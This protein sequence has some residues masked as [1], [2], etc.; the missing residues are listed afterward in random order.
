M[1]SAEMAATL[2]SSTRK[3]DWIKQMSTAQSA[4]QNIIM[5]SSVSTFYQ[6]PKPEQVVFQ[7]CAHA[8]GID[9]AP[10]AYAHILRAVKNAESAVRNGED[11]ARLKNIS[12]RQRTLQDQLRT[13]KA[14][15]ERLEAAHFE[16]LSKGTDS[17]LESARDA[18]LEIQGRIQLI[19]SEISQMNSI[20][21]SARAALG[22]AANAELPRLFERLVAESLEVIEAAAID[23]NAALDSG[24]RDAFTRL[25][26]GFHILGTVGND[27]R[28]LRSV[29]GDLGLSE[30]FGRLLSWNHALVVKYP[31]V[32]DKDREGLRVRI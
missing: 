5:D 9:P 27:S 23:I 16:A 1:T 6:D 24:A 21:I 19:E 20:E 17:E 4:P 29:C 13:T 15:A 2:L 12:G 28:N 25:A 10:T 26:I 8:L 7:Q 14:D 31:N 11:G 30:M 3:L 32:S 22:H 18:L